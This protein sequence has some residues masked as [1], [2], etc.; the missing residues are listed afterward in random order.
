MSQ[1]T[2]TQTR[3]NETTIRVNITV[4]ESE[5]LEDDTIPLV[6]LDVSG[7]MDGYR[8]NHALNAI[9]NLFKFFKF[10][11]LVTYNTS[12]TDKGIISVMPCLYAGGGTSFSSA[13]DEIQSILSRSS[14]KHIIFFTD[15]EDSYAIHQ[16]DRFSTVIKLKDSIIHTI[17]IDCGSDTKLL[18]NLSKAGNTEGTYG[19]CSSKIEKSYEDEI[20]RLVS[21]IKTCTK[22]TF[23]DKSYDVFDNNLNLYF[24]DTDSDLPLEDHYGQI[25]YLSYVFHNM[26]KDTKS[27][28]LQSVK[29]VQQEIQNLYSDAGRLS[30][31]ERKSVRSKLSP[32]YNIVTD[33]FKIIE[34]KGVCSNEQL[35]VLN[36]A[37][38][39]ARS[40]KFLKVTVSRFEKNVETFIEQDKHIQRLVDEKIHLQF[41]NTD[42]ED[43][44]CVLSLCNVQELLAN[45]DC[46]GI[47]IRATSN[48]VCM[49][50]PSRLK[51]DDFSTSYFGCSEFFEAAMINC[52]ALD[53]N[54]PSNIVLDSSRTAISGV[55]PLYLNDVHWK[56]ASRYLLRM[57]GHLCC[58]DPFNSNSSIILYTYL[59]AYMFLQEFSS[60]FHTKLAKL[61]FE[62][63]QKI[64]DM[65]PYVFPTPEQFCSSPENRVKSR[66]LSIDI[67]K[68]YHEKLGFDISYKNYILYIME[69]KLRRTDVTYTVPDLIDIDREQW[70]DCVSEPVNVGELDIYSSL[71]KDYPDLQLHLE[72]QIV[73]TVTKKV[74]LIQNSEEYA[75]VFRDNIS[76]NRSLSKTKN[77]LILLQITNLSKEGNYI[78]N[79]VDYILMSEDEAEKLLKQACIEY[80]ELS[81]KSI[82]SSSRHD[83]NV[84]LTD[85]YIKYLENATLLEWIAVLHSNCYY[86]RNI[87]KYYLAAA[88]PEVLLAL[89]TGQYD[90]SQLL[91][92][93]RPYIVSTYNDKRND[94][95]WKAGK[96][97][98]N[99][100]RRARKLLE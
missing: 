33:L 3:I 23:K 100:W 93:N 7:S 87:T 79:Y 25:D 13:Y 39:N 85:R 32:L 16:L 17:G 21:T 96:R 4:P 53:F 18:L 26:L 77:V 65:F 83:E 61:L 46:L 2:I 98:Y 68:F 44:S 43:Y 78:E 30:R 29:N 14:Y 73:R 37:A 97:L 5:K 56:I 91:K 84:A 20:T 54:I 6:V 28:D 41:D 57:C 35:A 71:L 52:D 99:K 63:I 49:M 10:I 64:S 69:E 15:G 95:P 75:I 19:Y 22:V 81:R 9:D 59:K 42:F 27:I 51:I 55:L 70:I 82:L 67:L 60:E 66:V 47:G 12:A 92:L 58:K 88:D 50:D 62:T 90:I 11:H 1:E 74:R 40:G 72:G 24:E 34:S 76:P 86:G 31:V 45:G 80:I 36:V 89:E 38:R 8:L 94:F 48:E